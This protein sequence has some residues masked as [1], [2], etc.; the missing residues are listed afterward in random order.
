MRP[1]FLSGQIKPESD[2]A[3]EAHVLRRRGVL[4]TGGLQGGNICQYTITLVHGKSS[5]EET[6]LTF[7]DF[8]CV[9]LLSYTISDMI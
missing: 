4:R 9:G 3:D 5:P 1:S 6:A 2:D 7:G 8:H